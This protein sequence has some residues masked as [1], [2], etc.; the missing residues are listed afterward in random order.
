MERATFQIERVYPAT[1]ERVFSAFQ[2]PVK[3]R[4]WFVDGKGTEVLSY[5][6][7]FRVEGEERTQFKMGPGTPVSGRVMENFTK[8]LEIQPNAR[9]VFAYTMSL[10]KKPF[11]ASLASIELRLEGSSTRLIFTE[12]AVFFEGADGAKMREH[13]WGELLNALGREY[14]A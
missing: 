11:S 1:P 2:D 5:E 6:S 9:L 12:Q 14:A 8:F 13:G 10:E 7:D 4:R 3:K